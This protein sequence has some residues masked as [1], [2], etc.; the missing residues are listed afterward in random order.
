MQPPLAS[1]SVEL[2]E[3]RNQVATKRDTVKNAVQQAS[4]SG[5]DLLNHAGRS[6]RYVLPEWPA[7]CF[8]QKQEK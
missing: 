1:S 4:L 8:A 7:E 5:T 3:W 2:N 6:K